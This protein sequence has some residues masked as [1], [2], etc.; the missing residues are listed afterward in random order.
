MVQIGLS[1]PVIYA[2]HSNSQEHGNDEVICLDQTIQKIGYT[3]YAIC[4]VRDSSDVNI[5]ETNRF[6]NY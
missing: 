6:F 4:Y 2:T 1:C 5:F 3:P